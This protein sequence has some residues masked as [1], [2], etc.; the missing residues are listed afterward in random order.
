MSTQEVIFVDRL[1]DLIEE[2]NISKAEIAR[3]FD[4]SYM[5]IINITNGK[6]ST[7]NV[8]F[9]CKVATLFNVS[10]DWLLGYSDN[11]E[12]YIKS[13]D[14]ADD[15]KI[16]EIFRDLMLSEKM[17]VS[18]IY[19]SYVSVDI[20]RSVCSDFVNKLYQMYKMKKDGII[21]D[22]IFGAW[23][24]EELSGKEG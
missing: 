23:I 7:I 5:T 20:D 12:V 21:S 8:E 16:K 18:E 6:Y 9:L 11:R 22:A 3:K 24:K 13:E 17:S 2:A 10:T 19:D 4:M 15:S 14:T 1:N